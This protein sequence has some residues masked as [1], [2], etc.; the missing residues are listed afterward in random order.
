MYSKFLEKLK[1][2][3]DGDGTLLDHSLMVYGAGM[4]DSNGHVSDPLPMVLSGGL[5]G[6]GHRHVELPVRTP[7]GNLW[8][9]VAQKFGVDIQT[10]GDSNGIANVV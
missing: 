9:N 8:R 2:T 4:A 3:K 1:A 7:V 10:F 5:V 6:E